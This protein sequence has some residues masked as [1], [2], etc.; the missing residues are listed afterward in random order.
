MS[1]LRLSGPWKS[2]W[3]EYRHPRL[4]PHEIWQTPSISVP[5]V[6]TDVLLDHGVLGG[7][8]KTGHRS[9][10]QTRPPHMW[11]ARRIEIYRRVSLV[12]LPLT[13]TTAS[14]AVAILPALS[15]VSMSAMT[16]C[17]AGGRRVRRPKRCGKRP[18]PPPPPPRRPSRACDR[19]FHIAGGIQRPSGANRPTRMPQERRPRPR[20]PCTTPPPQPLARMVRICGRAVAGVC[21]AAF[22]RRRDGAVSARRCAAGSPR[23]LVASVWLGSPLTHG[24]ARPCAVWYASCAVHT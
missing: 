15:C 9:T 8:L 23:S 3:R 22:V 7:H 14:R 11:R 5:R 17:G 24:I 4:L 21:G 18:P 2:R 1:Q 10:L 20:P 6:R 16:A 19:V 13:L 12:R